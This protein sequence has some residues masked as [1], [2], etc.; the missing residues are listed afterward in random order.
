MNLTLLSRTGSASVIWALLLAP[1]LLQG[2]F[3][4]HLPARPAFSA[5]CYLCAVAGVLLMAAPW[6]FRDLL[7][8]AALRPGV[9]RIAAGTATL[10]ALVFLLAA[11]FNL[12]RGS[13]TP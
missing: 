5:V 7:E 2:A 12:M 4:N 1:Q 6:R 8:R 11:T 9:R 10:S 13:A 3:D